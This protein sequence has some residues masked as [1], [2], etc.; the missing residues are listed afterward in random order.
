M[1]HCPRC[2]S[3]FDDTHVVCWSCRV[4]L[5]RGPAAAR[6][7]GERDDEADE[8]P[9]VPWVRP[10][11]IYLAPDELS[12]LRVAALLEDAEIA[13]RVESAQIPWIDGVM[14]NIKGYWGKVLVHP[15]DQEAA[16]ELVADYLASLGERDA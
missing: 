5:H 16:R 12:A 3:E 6:Q 4:R 1:R 13:A 2:L 15:D 11:A 7:G 14:S 10:V 9:G 8:G